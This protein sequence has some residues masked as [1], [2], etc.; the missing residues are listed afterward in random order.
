[1]VN[2]WFQRTEFSWNYISNS[3]EIFPDIDGME[4]KSHGTRCAGEI[5]MQPNN[6]ICGVGTAYGANIGGKRYIIIK[7]NH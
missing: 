4:Y 3:D 6:D 7:L 1:M 2:Y 5:I